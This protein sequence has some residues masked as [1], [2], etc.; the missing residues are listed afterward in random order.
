[1]LRRGQQGRAAI[2]SVILRTPANVSISPFYLPGRN[3]KHQAVNTE[4]GICNGGAQ[5]NTPPVQV[6]IKLS[7]S[8]ELCR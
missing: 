2:T 1:M 5:S 4:T 7:T 6:A 3:V 8:V